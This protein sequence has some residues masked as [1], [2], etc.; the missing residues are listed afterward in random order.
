MKCFAKHTDFQT[1]DSWACPKCGSSEIFIYDPAECSSD[2]CELLH[3]NDEILCEFCG[4]HVWGFEFARD[5]RDS[6]TVG[7]GD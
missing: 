7:Q 4:Y 2:N 6:Q 5:I 3:K 1:K